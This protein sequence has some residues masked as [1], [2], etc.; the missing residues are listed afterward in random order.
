VRDYQPKK[1]NPYLLPRNLYMQTVYMIRDYDRLKDEYRE[2]FDESPPLLDD[3][4]AVMKSRNITSLTEKK[5]IRLATASEKISAVDKALKQ[6]PKEYHDG[7]FSNVKYGGW[8]PNDA[9]VSTYR[10][11]KQ[12]FIYHTA[13]NMGFI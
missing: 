10:Y 11:W 5:A 7:V 8:F 3:N 6:V 1:N 2:I 12:R 9:A 13:Q 4:T